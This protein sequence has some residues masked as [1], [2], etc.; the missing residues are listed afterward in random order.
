[1]YRCNNNIVGYYRW[2]NLEQQC[3][4]HSHDRSYNGSCKWYKFRHS[5]NVLY[6]NS[7]RM[8]YYKYSYGLHDPCGDFAKYA[9]NGMYR[10]NNNIDRYYYRRQ[11][12]Q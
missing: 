12:E 2:R 1:M 8:L 3:F 4:G 9:D 10:S 6:R 7:N 5:Y 11:L